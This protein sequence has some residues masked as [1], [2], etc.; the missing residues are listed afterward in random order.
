[1]PTP[2]DEKREA[3]DEKMGLENYVD[4]HQE[5]NVD[6]KGLRGVRS[7]LDDSFDP[8]SSK[9]LSEL[10]PDLDAL[11]EKKDKLD[12][13]F[14]K[15]DLDAIEERIDKM[16]EDNCDQEEPMTI[17]RKVNMLS[18]IFEFTVGDRVT[19]LLDERGIVDLVGLD[20]RGVLYLVQYKE[21]NVRWEAEDCIKKDLS[22][23]SY[24]D[25]DIVAQ[26][27][28]IKTDIPEDRYTGKHRIG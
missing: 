20:R 17:E 18:K 9:P 10:K 11:M 2:D 19:N 24:K 3:M 7:E 23:V 28:N 12:P 5:K 1:M 21:N 15:P 25:D 16:A 14:T 27:P 8:L 4:E 13:E 22:Y 26:N 6:E